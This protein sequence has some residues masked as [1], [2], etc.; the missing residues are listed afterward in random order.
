MRRL[1]TPLVLALLV[2]AAPAAAQEIRSPYRFVEYGQ[3]LGAFVGWIGTDRGTVNLG[4]DGGLAFGVQYSLRIN[5][6]M[7]LSARAAYLSTEREIIDTATVNGAL[8]TRSEGRAPVDLLLVTARLQFTLTGARTWHGIA[9]HVFV[10]AGL[11]VATSEGENPVSVGVDNRY[12]FGHVF[13]GQV[14][15]GA[16]IFL[17]D[18]WALRVS[19]LDNLWQIAAP[20]GLQDVT[21]VPTAPDREWIHNLELSAGLHRYF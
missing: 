4:P 7:A 6:P 20:S 9:P 21:L 8:T 18:R 12:T 1:A 15:F 13:M 3:D 11:A 14:G 2:T 16:S 10:G 19:A 17:A 5:D